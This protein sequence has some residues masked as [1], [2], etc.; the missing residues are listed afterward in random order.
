MKFFRTRNV[1]FPARDIA[2]NA[3]YDFFVPEF[4][5]KFLNDFAVKNELDLGR[6]KV[7]INGTKII[8]H[9]H[10]SVNIPSGIHSLMAQNIALVAMNKSGVALKRK[11]I[12]G[13]QVIDSSY[14][15]EIHLNL[16][17][18]S[19]F[20]VE[21]EAGDKIVQFLP[22]YIDLTEQTNVDTGTLEDFYAGHKSKRGDGAF[23][24]T[25]SK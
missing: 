14:E 22:Y 3:G 6:N 11:L 9:P 7:E 20:D 1:K 23:G 21:I 18:T 2:E 13:A 25:G 17:N 10:G 12:F 4:D 24:S 16:I 5:E 15:G 8:V 19:D